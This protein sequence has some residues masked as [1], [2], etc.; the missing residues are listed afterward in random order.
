MGKA[1]AA[2]GLCDERAAA[3]GEDFAE[4]LAHA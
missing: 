2:G 1:L 4:W 3:P